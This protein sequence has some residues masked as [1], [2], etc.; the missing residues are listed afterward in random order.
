[1]DNLMKRLADK[2]IMY[3][4]VHIKKPRTALMIKVFNSSLEAQTHKIHSIQSLDA[5]DPS[6]LLEG[7]FKSITCSI[8]ATID[9]LMEGGEKRPKDYTIDDKVPNWDSLKPKAVLA[10]PPPPIGSLPKKEAPNQPMHVKIAPQP[11]SEGQQKIVSHALDVDNNEHIVLKQSKWADAR[12]NSIKR[13]LETAEVHA[14]AAKFCAEFNRAK[15][16]HIATSEL[17]FVKVGIM[18]VADEHK[19]ENVFFTYEHYLGGSDYVKFN[20]NFYYTPEHED[21]VLNDTCQA[22]SHFTWEKSG[23]QLVICDLQGVKFGSR[24]VLTDPVI[25]YANVLCYGSTNLGTRGI[26]RVIRMHKCNE[27]CRAMKLNPIAEDASP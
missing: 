23:K 6:T 1:M 2:N 4:F 11:F 19:K 17:Q 15:P 13:C 9:S 8:T 21:S 26:E 10:L 27:V 18:Q 24:V 7:V 25:H 5:S 3:H 22:F 12:S 20:S 14:I 16:Y